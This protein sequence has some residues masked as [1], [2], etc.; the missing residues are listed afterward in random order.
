MP[1]SGR[2]LGSAVLASDQACFKQAS[3]ACQLGGRVDGEDRFVGGSGRCGDL[4]ELVGHR[5][6]PVRCR[7]RSDLGDF[8]AFRTGR[9]YVG[10][11]FVDPGLAVDGRLRLS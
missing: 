8:A 9:C 1:R 7:A 11:D 5:A 3:G 6:G 4:G 10:K 2:H